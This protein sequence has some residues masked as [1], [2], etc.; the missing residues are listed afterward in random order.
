MMK[1]ERLSKTIVSVAI[2][3]VATILLWL[4]YDSGKLPYIIFLIGFG[5]TILIIVFVWMASETWYEIPVIPVKRR[6]K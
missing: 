3:I 6:R 4:S 2:F 5:L 1:L